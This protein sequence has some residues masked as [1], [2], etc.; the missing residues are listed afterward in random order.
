M[1]RLLLLLAFAAAASAFH[2]GIAAPRFE[3]KLAV[4]RVAPSHVVMEE[5]SEKAVVVGAAAVGGLVGIY[6]FKEISAG[7]LWAVV[8]AYGA[9]LSNGFGSFS[10]SA[11]STAS[12]AYSKALDLNDQ[13]DVVPKA[14]TALDT[15][16][17]AAG[18]LNENYGIT[19]KIDEKL[20][21]SKYVALASSKVDDVKSSVTDKIDDLKAA[22]DKK[23]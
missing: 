3:S 18:N 13:Y 11:G 8:L 15:V 20:E 9:T 23:A 14:K 16:T 2:Q 4:S 10:K 6:L 1:A 22:A 21:V 19:A 17:T 7:I 5:P 12:K